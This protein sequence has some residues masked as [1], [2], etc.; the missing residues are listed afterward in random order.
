M[1]VGPLASPPCRCA[2]SRG[3]TCNLP[4]TAAVRCRGGLPDASS[5]PWTAI[6]HPDAQ[7]ASQ[8]CVVG[9]RG[10]DPGHTA[11]AAS[12]RRHRG[13]MST[14]P[15]KLPVP[16]TPRACCCLLQTWREIQ[17]GYGKHVYTRKRNAI[18]K[19]LAGTAAALIVKPASKRP[20]RSTPELLTRAWP[21]HSAAPAPRKPQVEFMPPGVQLWWMP[22]LSLVTSPFAPN[23]LC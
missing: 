23:T 12:Q 19:K 8:P 16:A 21:G 20:W 1:G 22:L 15:T 14:H 4:V 6:K 18:P 17:Q 9:L 13:R 11:A 10:E 2:P 3:S 5:C 7:R